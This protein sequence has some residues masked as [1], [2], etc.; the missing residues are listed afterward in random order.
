MM[1]LPDFLTRDPDGFIRPTDYR[2]GLAHVVY[3]HQ[4]HGYSAE[5][6]FCRYPMLPLAWIH[7]ALAFYLEN[8][9]EVDAYMAP[10]LPELEKQ[11]A[12]YRRGMSQVRQRLEVLHQAELSNP[13]ERI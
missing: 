3:L 8:R 13:L 6:L 4:E 1:N 12:A 11:E 2:V 5:T 7:K 9:A 10:Y